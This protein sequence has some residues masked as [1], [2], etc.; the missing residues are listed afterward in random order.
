MSEALASQVAAGEVVERPASVL[1]ELIENSIDAGARSISIDIRRGGTVLLRVSDDGLGMGREDAVLALQRHATSKLKELSDLMEITHLGFRG[2]ALPSIASVSR[3]RLLTRETG[4]LEGTEIVVEGGEVKEVRSSGVADGTTIEVAD[5]F[6][7]IPA[8]RKFLRSE[9]AEYGHAEHQVRLHALAFPEVRFVLRKDNRTVYDHAG[10]QDTRVRLSQFLG[11]DGAEKLI[12]VPLTHGSGFSVEGYVMPLSE[13]RRSRKQ[14][15]VFLNK[16]P[17]E[18]ALVSRAIRDGFVGLPQGMYPTVFLYIDMEPSLVD[19]N[20]HP[21]KREV[22]FR[23]A[24]ELMSVIILALNEALTRHAREVTGWESSGTVVGTETL[25]LAKSES[26]TS[27]LGG[28]LPEA[29]PIASPTEAPERGLIDPKKEGRE[30]LMRAMSGEKDLVIEPRVVVPAMRKV[31]APVRHGELPLPKESPKENVSLEEVTLGEVR[32]ETPIKRASSDGVIV[33]DVIR[34]EATLEEIKAK[35]DRE[36][37][38]LGILQGRYLLWE[39]S[40]GLVIMNP[41]AARE[42]ILFER[43]LEGHKREGI[44]MQK[45]LI[46]VIVEVDGRDFVLM[47][48]MLAFFG[49]AGFQITPFGGRSFQIEAMPAFVEIQEVKNFVLELLDTLLATGFV[50]RA[51]AFTY[52]VFALHLAASMVRDERSVAFEPYGLMDDLM[53]CDIPYCTARNKPTLYP[54]SLFDIER[55]LG[56]L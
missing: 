40:E 37:R 1:K 20:V 28:S 18:D 54:I 52:E 9:E 34:E 26:L 48:E 12:S 31:V 2:E 23:R 46:P 7:N 39:G 41:R 13:V 32:E 16:R 38:F 4:A 49:E 47:K 10:V 45:L 21:A 15:Y 6:Y 30:A 36:F 43:F 35:R 53:A 14:Q 55:K 11:R 56:K 24:Q 19:V 3:F 27:E 42:R 44:P 51:K 5:L 50:K 33:G 8:R 25:D 22:R 17:I 29:T